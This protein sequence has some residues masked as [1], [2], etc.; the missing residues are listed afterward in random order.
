MK[1]YIHL[2]DGDFSDK[3]YESHRCY[4]SGARFREGDYCIKPFASNPYVNMDPVVASVFLRLDIAYLVLPEDIPGFRSRTGGWEFWHDLL[5]PYLELLGL[6]R[7]E[8]EECACWARL[9]HN[10]EGSDCWK[11]RSYR[12][13]S[14]KGMRWGPCSKCGYDGYSCFGDY[15]EGWDD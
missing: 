3:N 9:Y 15:W 13:R 14:W 8:A 5:P 12:P 1:S 6:D 11:C 4:V 2:Y 10:C 7:E